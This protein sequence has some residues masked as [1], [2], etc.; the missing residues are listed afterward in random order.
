MPTLHIPS[1]ALT[2]S[3]CAAVMAYVPWTM[4]RDRTQVIPGLSLWVLGV[5]CAA[6]G[7]FLNALQG[8]A[9]DWLARVASNTFILFSVAILGAGAD[10]FQGRPVPWA[11]IFTLAGAAL[12]ITALWLYVWDTMRVRLVGVSLLLAIAAGVTSRAFARERREHFRPASLVGAVPTAVFALLMLARAGEAA[13]NPA[14]ASTHSPTPVNTITYLFGGVLLPSMIAGA[15]MLVNEL[16]AAQLREWVYRDPLTGALN[17][18]AIET[19]LPGWLEAHAAP[20]QLALIDGNGFK[21]VNDELGHEA[22]DELLRAMVGAIDRVRPSDSLFVRMGGD[23]FAL[24]CSA[25]ADPAAFLTRAGEACLE[26]LKANRPAFAWPR[27][28]FAFGLAAI[29]TH[30]ASGFGE[31][32][33]VADRNLALA[34]RSL[35]G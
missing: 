29:Q 25:D 3:L 16:R 31:A 26:E 5:A 22:G 19:R 18:R 27:T 4:S 12:L 28:V 14:S 13:F 30:S 1:I 2:L 35:A 23:E 7:L 11:R 15:L 33:R 24:V 34:K 9:P 17:R 32:L 8:I 10:V 21:R 20:A 6:L